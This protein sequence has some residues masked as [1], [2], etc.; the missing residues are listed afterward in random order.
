[1]THR[2]PRGCLL[3]HSWQKQRALARS[4]CLQAEEDRKNILRLQDLVDKLQ[5]KVKAYK[6]QAEEA[7]SAGPWAPWPRA[8]AHPCFLGPAFSLAGCNHVLRRPAPPSWPTGSKPAPPPAPPGLL[9]P[10][11]WPSYSIP[12]LCLSLGSPTQPDSLHLPLTPHP[13]PWPLGPGT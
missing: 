4:L 3:D 12:S 9:A 8:G 10:Q 11:T 6:R 5:A 1:M 2:N 13:A 7:V